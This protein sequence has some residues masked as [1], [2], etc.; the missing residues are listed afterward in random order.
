MKYIPKL[1]TA[2]ALSAA[3]LTLTSCGAFA[4]GFREGLEESQ[5]GEI[6]VGA[7][8]E[9]G[10]TFIN[11]WSNIKFTMP[12]EGYTAATQEQ[13]NAMMEAGG[14]A[15]SQAGG[16]SDAAVDLM[17]M[18][19]VHDFMITGAGTGIPTMQLYYE[20]VGINPAMNGLDESDYID[21][22]TSQFEPLAS[23]G[24][25]YT[26]VGRDTATIAGIE[27]TVGMYTI[28]DAANLDYYLRLTDGYMWQLVVMYTQDTES[29]A[30]DLLAAMSAAE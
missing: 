16:Q 18:R 3:L 12:A 17:R 27:W 2:L 7:W 28:N 22:M 23:Q 1:F 14:E 11:E 29:G 25:I 24:M 10:K 9:D 5:R 6:Q 30:N 26:E 21:L 4:S 19:V 8:S 20:N 13:I 15:V